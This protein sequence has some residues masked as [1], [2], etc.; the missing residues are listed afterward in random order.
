LPNIES[1]RIECKREL[2][3]SLERSVVAFLNYK[4][5]GLLYPYGQFGATHDLSND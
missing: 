1:N 4:E 5:G 3:D 2:G